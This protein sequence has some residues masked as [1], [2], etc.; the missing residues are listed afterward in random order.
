MVHH[1]RLEKLAR[2]DFLRMVVRL[3]C[4]LGDVVLVPKHIRRNEGGLRLA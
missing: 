2:G 3:T 1:E 4:Q